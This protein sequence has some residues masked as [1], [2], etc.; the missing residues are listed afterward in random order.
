MTSNG[1]NWVMRGMA[2]ST[3]IFNDPVWSEQE[4][5]MQ[6]GERRRGT[7]NPP[8]PST[9]VDALHARWERASALQDRMVAEGR[10]TLPIEADP[11]SWAAVPGDMLLV[12]RTADRRGIRWVPAA[13][14]AEYRALVATPLPGSTDL[15]A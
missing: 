12:G 9:H 6:R 3:I 10:D 1:S 8:V 13:L 11:R 4:Y 5:A 14:L 7:F 2:A 15:A